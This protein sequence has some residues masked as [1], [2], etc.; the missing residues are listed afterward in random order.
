MV[1]Y[2]FDL[3]PTS[4][5]FAA[6]E[7]MHEGVL[8]GYKKDG[9]RELST[10]KLLNHAMGHIVAF[11]QG[12]RSDSHLAAAIVRTMM[13]YEQWLETGGVDFDDDGN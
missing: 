9:W 4:A 13:A 11:L 5:M 12:D 3:L 1:G 7:R 8:K 6:A 10:A 2:R